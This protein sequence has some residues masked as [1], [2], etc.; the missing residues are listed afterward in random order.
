[1][2]G[3]LDNCN[4]SFG[5]YARY[6]DFIY[7]DK[8][9]RSEG[10]FVASCLQ[11]QNPQTKS[12]IDL[13]CGTGRHAVIFSEL[14]FSVLGIDNSA[15]MLGQARHTLASAIPEIQSLLCFREGDIRDFRSVDKFDAAVALF[16]VM[17]YQ[18]TDSDLRATISSARE[19]LVPGGI[20]LFDFWHDR[21]V[22]KDLPAVRVKRRESQD[23]KLVRISEPTLHRENGTVEIKYD[24]FAVNKHTGT[25]EE[26]EEVHTMRYFSIANL[27]NVLADCGFSC[28]K[29]A[30]WMT[31][32]PP[33]EDTFSVYC[34]A[35]AIGQV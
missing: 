32:L 5:V 28:I 3:S 7:S 26:I 35:K 30:D 25:I 9:Y 22:L 23:I 8:D 18:I 24:A 2:E 19:H 6:Y 12:V 34:I 15:S 33:S 13:G 27:K 10:M 31:D 20:F 14:G 11:T 29:F 21:A 4:R 1:M 17:S 16:H